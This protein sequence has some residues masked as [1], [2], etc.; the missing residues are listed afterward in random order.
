MK[1]WDDIT[2]EIKA[3]RV[4]WSEFGHVKVSPN[5]SGDLLIFN[6]TNE[7]AYERRWNWFERVSRGLI[8]D[9]NTGEIIALPFEKFFNWGENG[10]KKVRGVVEVAEKHDGSL[11]ILYPTTPR[12]GARAV[13]TRGSFTSDQA[14][15][16]T[17][18]LQKNYDLSSLPNN[19][20]L[21]FEII[22]PD[23]RIVVDYGN[24]KDLIL[25]G[26]RNTET[27]QDYFYKDV[28]RIAKEFGFSTPKLFDMSSVEEV[29][30]TANNLDWNAEGYVIRYRDGQ[31][32]K[33]KGEEYVRVHRVRHGLSTKAIVQLASENKID[34]LIVELPEEFREDLEQMDEHFN[35][36]VDKKIVKI[37]EVYN[38][39][40]KSTRKE[41]ALYLQGN[42][43]NLLSFV[44][45]LHTRG[46]LALKMQV[47]SHVCK[48]Y[49]DYF[50]DI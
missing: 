3:G 24:R 33:I 6:Y 17:D 48:Y 31:R 35:D 29:K 45:T 50:D 34:D 32:C 43:P 19:L 42:H 7:A 36:I 10:F 16:A 2:K 18:F 8:M 13:A 37:K 49:R 27:H 46:D 1:N 44:M 9:A 25:L 20:T 4:D 26:V 21:L 41:L 12:G 11:G 14:M 30:K 28:Q 23:N 22:Y 5:S 47:E 40:P 39:A 38:K 15:F